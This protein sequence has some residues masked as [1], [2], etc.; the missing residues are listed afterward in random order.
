VPHA[1]R[2]AL[3]VYVLIVGLLVVW[4]AGSIA[5]IALGDWARSRWPELH[6]R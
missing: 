6:R 5:L 4:F 3:I 1:L 2:F